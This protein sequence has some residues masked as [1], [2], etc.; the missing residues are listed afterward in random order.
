MQQPILTVPSA[1]DAKQ[2]EP[3]PLEADVLHKIA[4]G[5]GK[6]NLPSIIVLVDPEW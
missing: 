5:S 1:D 6:P 4:G 2:A 3:I